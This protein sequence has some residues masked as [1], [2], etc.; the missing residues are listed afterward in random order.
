MTKLQD[1]D[2]VIRHVSRTSNV[3]A[4]ALSHPDGVERAPRKIDT[5]L[6]ERFFSWYLSRNEEEEQENHAATIS[7]NHDLPTAGHPGIKRTLSLLTRKG[8]KWK[9]MQ[10]D[11]KKYVEGCIICQKNKP[12]VGPTPNSL[13]P[14]EVPVSP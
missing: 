6:L 1:Y 8:H 14:L 4:N 12:R 7:Q 3:L 5:L 13:H 9:G 10:M 11:I 2:F